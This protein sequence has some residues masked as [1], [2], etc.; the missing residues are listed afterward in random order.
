MHSVWIDLSGKNK[1]KFIKERK[2]LLNNEFMKTLASDYF[3]HDE[4]SILEM[5]T[6]M[7]FTI[8]GYSSLSR[9]WCFD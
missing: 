8:S 9:V 3:H 6:R 5:K 7:Q 2:S 4:Y 1:N